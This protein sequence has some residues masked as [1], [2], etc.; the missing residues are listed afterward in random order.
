MSLQAD[1]KG[2]NSRSHNAPLMEQKIAYERSRSGL[3]HVSL[4]SGNDTGT[5][6]SVLSTVFDSLQW[7]NYDCGTAEGN[8]S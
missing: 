3:E 2:A 7:F 4:S 1:A 6:L 8:L 5:L